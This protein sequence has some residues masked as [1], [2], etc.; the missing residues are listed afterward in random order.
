MAGSTS[1]GGM[2]GSVA[3]TASW[4]TLWFRRLMWLG[5]AANLVVAA[6]S[7]MMPEQVLAFLGLAPAQ[8]LVW[9]RF[10]VFLLIL[11]SG[12]YIPSAVDPLR[13]SYSAVGAVL[14]RFGGVLFFALIG[15]GYII[16]GL[17]D[18]IFGLPQ[19]VLLLLAW[20]QVGHVSSAG[21]P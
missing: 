17:F 11:L 16:F 21:S 5:I 13:N 7:L 10:A 8:P 20:R 6:I 15:D 9:P 3:G 19:G 4:A 12:F 2:G 14:S 1:I 18:L